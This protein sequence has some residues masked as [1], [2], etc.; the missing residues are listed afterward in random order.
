MEAQI[1]ELLAL[2]R[3]A[4]LERFEVSD[5][6]SPSYVWPECL[7]Y[8]LRETARDNHE[9]H[10]R[11]L[12]ALVM[13]RYGKPF[14][15]SEV[16]R[17]GKTLVDNSLSEIRDRATQPFLEKIV[18]DRQAR[19]GRLDIY[20]IAFALAVARDRSD[21]RRAVLRKV[22]REEP[23]YAE[24]EDGG[25]FTPA[26]EK[27]LSDAVISEL[28]TGTDVANDRKRVLT[29]IDALPEKYRKVATMRMNNLPFESSDPMHDLVRDVI[30]QI[31]RKGENGD[32]STLL[33]AV[34]TESDLK[35]HGYAEE[36]RR[37][38]EGLV[39]YY[40]DSRRGLKGRASDRLIA[41][42]TDGDVHLTP[43]EVL[44]GKDG[45]LVFRRIKTGHRSK[46]S[47]S[48]KSEA[49]FPMAVAQMFP[50]AE[51]EIVYLGDGEIDTATM[52]DSKKTAERRKVMDG[53][54]ADIGQGRFPTKESVFT[55][56]TCPAFFVC[57]PVPPGVLQ[58]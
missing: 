26:V 47:A 9:G 44:E 54:I 24:R 29:A 23:L 30:D 13:A 7:V 11:S 6:K 14:R 39:G 38:A 19:D 25:E 53:L 12:F 48:R 56:P 16:Q 42:L 15:P 43:D 46:S 36:F 4:Q 22:Q 2:S 32:A 51:A 50:G 37:I 34:W 55:C 52:L 58:K 33:D 5:P 1:A 8:F 20:E 17:E 31:V 27:A 3:E 18:A 35:E 21:A 10:F 40:L 45:R 28:T 57:G 49:L 41:V